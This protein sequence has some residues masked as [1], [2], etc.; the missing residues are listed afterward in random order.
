MKK[1]CSGSRILCLTFMMILPCFC[2]CQSSSAHRSYTDYPTDKKPVAHGSGYYREEEQTPE[3]QAYYRDVYSGDW[4]QQENPF[5]TGPSV[6]KKSGS[7]T[8]PPHWNMMPPGAKTMDEIR[9]EQAT[10]N[11]KYQMPPQNNIYPVQGMNQNYVVS[12]NNGQVT[13]P[14]MAVNPVMANSAAVNPVMTNPAA[15]NPVMAKPVTGNPSLPQ[16]NM[17]QPPNSGNPARTGDIYKDYLNSRSEISPMD[18]E[19]ILVK[20]ASRETRIVRGQV[21]E[22]DTDNEENAVSEETSSIGNES[23][24][25]QKE[26]EK[27]VRIGGKVLPMVIDPTIAQPWADVHRPFQSEPVVTELNTN[28]YIVGGGDSKDPVY[29][30]PDWAVKHLD[31]EDTVA[32]FDT[33]DG[34]ILVEPS[35][36]VQI[37]S[38]RFGSVR[39]ILGPRESDQRTTLFN[40]QTDQKIVQHIQSEGI[41]IRSQEEKASF[42]RAQ[43]RAVGVNA[44]TLPQSASDEKA[45]MVANQ[46]T[47]LGSMMAAI[48]HSEIGA[49]DKAA[50]MDGAAAAQSWGE[51]QGVAVSLDNINVGTNV[52]VDGPSVIYSVKDDTKTSKLRLIKIA[53][54]NA[55]K[56]GELIEFTIRFENIGDQVIGNV[57]ILDNL[58]SRLT[59]LENSAKSSHV[60]EFLVETNEQGSLVLRWEIT[61]PLEP[62][63]F[64]IVQ[65]I[66]KV[67]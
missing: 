26:T 40:I 39:Q 9:R 33:V 35:N 25:T 51:V 11:P 18:S 43:D 2:S 5:Y 53:S 52:Y 1:V 61:D 36:Q 38:P 14:N 4:R 28:E 57:T 17:P 16:Q 24:Q 8:M 67:R 47:K 48:T 54:K 44:R 30:T 37:Y 63:E 42:T 59:Y 41:D 3:E 10:M 13:G 62:G 20:K 55:A 7:T 50:L 56:P 6:C 29:S 58:S 19:T 21:P 65:F 49:D 45:A 60:G 27:K 22:S 46:Q 66:G 31:R 23:P 15:V 12:Q 32:H 34:A 64:G